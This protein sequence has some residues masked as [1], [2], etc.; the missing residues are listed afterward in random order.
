MNIIVHYILY[1]GNVKS[2]KD[3]TLYSRLFLVKKRHSVELR[4]CN[5]RR[6]VMELSNV[7]YLQKYSD[8]IFKTEWMNHSTA[9]CQLDAFTFLNV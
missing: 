6:Q 9:R 5:L 7:G 8:T 3:E 4:I 2:I 1:L